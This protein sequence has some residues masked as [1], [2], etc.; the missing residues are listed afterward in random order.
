MF[1]RAEFIKRMS[2]QIVTGEFVT[3]SEQYAKVE[4]DCGFKPDFIQVLM[5]FESGHTIATYVSK[6]NNENINE[7]DLRPI[8]GVRYDIAL[9]QETGETGISDIT[10]TG[11]KYRCNASNTQG[12]LCSYKAVKFE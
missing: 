11:F 1:F 6:D 4:I 3:G 5:D 7:W 2:G 10:N 12:K 8:E 9:G